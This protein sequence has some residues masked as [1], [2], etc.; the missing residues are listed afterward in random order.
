MDV[1]LLLPLLLC[2]VI[3]T[4]VAIYSSLNYNQCE[5]KFQKIQQKYDNDIKPMNESIKEYRIKVGELVTQNEK[6]EKSLSEQTSMNKLFEKN[7]IGNFS[8]NYIISD[9]EDACVEV[10]KDK[11]GDVSFL[12]LNKNC[13]DP[14]KYSIFNY[15]PVDRQLIVK[16]DDTQRCVEAFNTNDVI[17]NDC[18]KTS[19]RQK[20][21]YY[22]LY[23]GKFK[24]A[25]YSK[26]LGYNPE[27]NIIELQ[28]CG[29]N[30]NIKI[31]DSLRKEQLFL[32]NK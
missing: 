30:T 3:T 13:F 11:K 25:V 5:S 27:S 21:N 14:K 20:F 10:S 24:S 23:D 29:D 15:D 19:Q 12:G 9:K 2:F 16:I 7:I 18:I 31:K 32:E 22:P 26:C 17:L 6:Y 28:K 8:N 1:L 4:L